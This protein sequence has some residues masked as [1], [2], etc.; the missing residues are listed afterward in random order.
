[1][2]VEPHDGTSVFTKETSDS[3]SALAPGEVTDTLSVN[4]EAGPHPTPDLPGP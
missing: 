4:Q 3:P 1:M 2:R